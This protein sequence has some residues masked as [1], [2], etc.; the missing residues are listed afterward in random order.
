MDRTSTLSVR[1]H[2]HC[3]IY[4]VILLEFLI[5]PGPMVSMQSLTKLAD[6]LAKIT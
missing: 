5:P 1:Y 4:G 6:Y 2:L 3:I